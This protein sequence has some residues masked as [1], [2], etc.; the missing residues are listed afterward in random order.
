MV[1]NIRRTWAHRC[2]YRRQTWHWRSRRRT[3]TAKLRI[4]AR[5]HLS[6]ESKI[7]ALTKY[8]GTSL[9]ITWEREKQFRKFPKSMLDSFR[10]I[11]LLI[12]P[13]PQLISRKSLYNHTFESI[14]PSLVI[15]PVQN[16]HEQ[17]SN[18]SKIFSMLSIDSLKKNKWVRHLMTDKQNVVSLGSRDI[19]LS[20]SCLFR[21]N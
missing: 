11:R 17:N 14:I 6:V 5:G 13:L 15:T 1:Y 2:Y 18:N 4:N 21:D 12:H 9:W 3:C 8:T 19:Y 7:W 16:H 20:F 10:K